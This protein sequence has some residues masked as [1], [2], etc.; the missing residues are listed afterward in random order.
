MTEKH[1]LVFRSALL[2][3]AALLPSVAEAQGYALSQSTRS[4]Q[5]I[6]A[7]NG[8]NKRWWAGDRTM[9]RPPGRRREAACFNSSRS[10]SMCSSTS[11]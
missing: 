1:D 11:I 7:S 10:S 6:A 3:L 5:S 9:T 4:F 2:T 8:V